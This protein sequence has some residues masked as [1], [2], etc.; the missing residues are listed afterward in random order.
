MK[1]NEEMFVMSQRIDR[2]TTAHETVRC[3][4]CGHAHS[5]STWHALPKVRTLTGADV[6]P[7]VSA[8]PSGI[9]VEVRPCGACGRSIARTSRALASTG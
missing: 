1:V 4:G 6:H 8:W 3:G 9:L 5:L 2:E 7:Y